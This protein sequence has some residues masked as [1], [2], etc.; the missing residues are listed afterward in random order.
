PRKHNLFAFSAPPITPSIPSVEATAT[1]S[2]PGTHCTTRAMAPQ[3]D[4]DT[5]AFIQATVQTLVEQFLTSS[6]DPRSRS[7]TPS[8]E[9]K[10]NTTPGSKSFS[11]TWEAWTRIEQ[12]L[13]LSR[14]S[15]ETTLS[16]GDASSARSTT[17][18]VANGPSSPL[19]TSGRRSTRPTSIL[20]L[21]RPP[22]RI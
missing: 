1:T 5:Q 12:S 16:A 19:T 13:R 6:P 4:E 17:F 7:L 21:S 18:P 10:R 22:R 20:T 2:A 9:L 11:S 15:V 8:M 14:S 3:I